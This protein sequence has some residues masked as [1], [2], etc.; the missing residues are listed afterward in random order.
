MICRARK[1]CEEH[2]KTPS[3]QCLQEDNTLEH[4]HMHTVCGRVRCMQS[5]FFH[6]NFLFASFACSVCIAIVPAAIA[7]VGWLGLFR[8]IQ[9]K[10]KPFECRIRFAYTV[11]WLNM[12]SILSSMLV[13]MIFMQSFFLSRTLHLVRSLDCGR[14]FVPYGKRSRMSRICILCQCMYDVLHSFDFFC[15]STRQ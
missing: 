13:G 6:Y 8:A 12:N 5:I 9:A 14:L 3:I 10:V 7:T 4:T 1:K 2:T 11:K 15:M